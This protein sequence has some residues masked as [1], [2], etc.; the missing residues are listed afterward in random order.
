MSS[1]WPAVA[2]F[3]PWCYIIRT[4]NL[5]SV[6][7]K[8]EQARIIV[9]VAREKGWGLTGWKKKARKAELGPPLRV[10]V[11]LFKQAKCPAGSRHEEECV[12]A[13]N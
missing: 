2:F 7:S 4:K 10:E 9:F 13:G 1:G 6:N 12:G 11:L 5:E 3:E 8:V